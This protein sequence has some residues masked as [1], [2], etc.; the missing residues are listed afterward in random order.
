MSD[1]A[2]IKKAIHRVEDCLSITE[3]TCVIEKAQ[4]ERKFDIIFRFTEA[5]EIDE[6]DRETLREM[7]QFCQDRIDTLQKQRNGLLRCFLKEKLNSLY[8]KWYRLTHKS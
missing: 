6:A 3:Q 4:D 1:I 8:L 2:D 5:I 7:F